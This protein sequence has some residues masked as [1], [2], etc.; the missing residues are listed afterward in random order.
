MESIT[1]IIRK[2][3]HDDADASI[4]VEG[5]ICTSKDGAKD[6]IL[7]E[8]N[9]GFKT[10]CKSLGELSHLLD[11]DLEECCSKEADEG[12]PFEFYWYDNGK[13]EEFNIVEVGFGNEYT[14]LITG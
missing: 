7:S 12:C 8:L 13:G 9:E 5:R 1:L 2:T 6:V 3:Y 14:N 10:N 4:S 11:E